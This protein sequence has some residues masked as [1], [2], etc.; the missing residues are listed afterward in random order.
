[1]RAE[2][3]IHLKD[4]MINDVPTNSVGKLIVLPSTFIGSPR[5]LH[6]YTQDAMTYVRHGGKP[7]LFITFTCNPKDEELLSVME[8]NVPVHYRQDLIARVFHQKIKIFHDLIVKGN[9]KMRK[10]NNIH[11]TFSIRPNIW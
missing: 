7:S 10:V 4:A 5:Y 11:V 1:M 9:V 8:D 3:Y 6:E 2:N